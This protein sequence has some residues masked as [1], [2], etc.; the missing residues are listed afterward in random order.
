MGCQGKS[1]ASAVQSMSMIARDE[2]FEV[3]SGRTVRYDRKAGSG[4]VMYDLSNNCVFA[5]FTTTIAVRSPKLCAWMWTLQ[6]QSG[7][8][9]A[10]REPTKGPVE[11]AFC[12]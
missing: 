12:L 6:A 5:S 10:G 9:R 8:R 2:D 4:S 11:Q 1:A 7:V 3:P